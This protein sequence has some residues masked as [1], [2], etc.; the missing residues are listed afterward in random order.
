MTGLR[1]HSNGRTGDE[2][3]RTWAMRAN[4]GAWDFDIKLQ[5]A[6]RLKRGLLCGALAALAITAL[7]WRISQ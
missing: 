4:D 7:I 1:F 6:A 5:R 3:P 2:P